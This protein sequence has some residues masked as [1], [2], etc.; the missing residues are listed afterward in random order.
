MGRIAAGSLTEQVTLTLPALTVPS[1]R[2][3][4]K[5]SGTVGPSYQRP[6]AVRVVRASER[7]RNGLPLT[8]QAWEVTVRAQQPLA[9]D[10]FLKAYQGHLS[11][12][13]ETGAVVSV[14]PDARGEYLSLLVTNKLS[15]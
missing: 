5:P 2:G 6:A 13:T 14:E 8:A 3:S 15:S 11:W 4:Q 12:Q 7:V 1:N 9:Q 10:P